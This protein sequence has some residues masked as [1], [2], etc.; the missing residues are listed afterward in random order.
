VKFFNKK[1][2]LQSRKNLVE[3][4][5]IQEPVK[6]EEELSRIE[7]TAENTVSKE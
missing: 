6:K 3:K 1:K 4:A 2:S 5:E 7:N